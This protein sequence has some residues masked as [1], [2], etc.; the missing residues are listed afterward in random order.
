MIMPRGQQLLLPVNPPS[1][2]LA[3]V[4]GMLTKRSCS[5]LPSFCIHA[6]YSLSKSMRSGDCSSPKSELVT[7]LDSETIIPAKYFPSYLCQPVLVTVPGAATAAPK[8]G[9]KPRPAQFSKTVTTKDL[10]IRMSDGTVL[11]AHHVGFVAV[12]ENFCRQTPRIV[13]RSHDESVGTG[14]QQSNA[15]PRA[16]CG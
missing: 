7:L 13:V 11:R 15:V 2:V 4:I 8:S 6:S 10:A 1:V 9:W 12:D 5:A 16:D 3:V 14:T